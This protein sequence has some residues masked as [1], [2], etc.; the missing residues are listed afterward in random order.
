MVLL[1]LPLEAEEVVGEMGCSSRTSCTCCTTFRFI[2][3][4][5]VIFWSSAASVPVDAE[6]TATALLAVIKTLASWPDVL[7]ILDDVEKTYNKYAMVDPYAP[8]QTNAEPPPPTPYD[9]FLPLIKSQIM[10][11]DPPEV[12]ATSSM[13]PITST[14][15]GHHYAQ[16]HHGVFGQAPPPP[17]QLMVPKLS[18]FS[19]DQEGQTQIILALLE[20]LDRDMSVVGPSHPLRSKVP[21]LRKAAFSVFRLDRLGEEATRRASHGKRPNAPE[22]EKASSGG[23]NRPEIGWAGLEKSKASAKGLYQVIGCTGPSQTWSSRLWRGY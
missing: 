10:D 8:R 18:M 20:R 13:E 17:P 14:P 5:R 12:P 23:V 22:G 4:S 21:K 19:V 7:E 6:G 1:C 16:Q 2:A 3:S 9:A 11:W 15:I